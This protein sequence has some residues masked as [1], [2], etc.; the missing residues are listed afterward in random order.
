MNG[1]MSKIM[2]IMILLLMSSTTLIS[3]LEEISDGDFPKPITIGQDTFWLFTDQQSIMLENLIDGY[4]YMEEQIN[5]YQEKDS[6][7]DS[8]EGLKDA[9]IVSQQTSIET[10]SEAM[11]TSTESNKLSG[12]VVI[13]TSRILQ[14]KENDYKKAGKWTT[15]WRNT[16]LVAIVVA[17][18]EAL[19]IYL[20]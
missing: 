1:I 4:I 3:Q 7:T 5:A 12:E 14:S 2:K 6:I 19:I 17:A 9:V 18:F 16:A 20:I 15:R 10:L 8:V 13:S 11:K